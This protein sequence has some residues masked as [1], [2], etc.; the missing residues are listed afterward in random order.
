[1]LP[2]GGALLS[3][4]IISYAFINNKHFR[5]MVIF[6]KYYTNDR[7]KRNIRCGI[8]PFITGFLN[9][10][11]GGKIQWL[12]V[13]K[14]APTPLCS[15]RHSKPIRG[16]LPARPAAWVPWRSLVCNPTRGLLV[17]DWAARSNTTGYYL[18][19]EYSSS[20]YLQG[21]RIRGHMESHLFNE[22]TITG[23]IRY[24]STAFSSSTRRRGIPST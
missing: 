10:K 12:K 15:I 24:S 4:I 9:T 19:L 18:V 17:G 6:C 1:M 22:H 21:T 3:Q 8:I 11:I 5:F 20:A 23:V 16:L 2:P 13:R 7:S 14:H